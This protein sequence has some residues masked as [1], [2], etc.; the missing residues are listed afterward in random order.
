VR[1]AD[2]P[3]L[4]KDFIETAEGLIFAVVSYFPEQGKVGCFLRYVRSENG[5]SK[6][7]TE[8]ANALLM[9]KYPHYLFYS[10]QFDTSYHAVAPKDIV[11][12]HKPE[13]K[14]S[15]VLALNEPEPISHKLQQLIAILTQNGAD[16]TC[17]GLTGSML[18][19][20]QKLTSDVDL[21]VYG[22]SAFHTAR[23]AVQL[24]INGQLISE[25]DDSLMRD[26][27]ER[28]AADLSYDDFAWHEYRKFNKASIEGTKFDIG[29][30][31]LPNELTHDDEQY[32]KKGKTTLTAQ[33]IND[34]LAYDFP[35]RYIIDDL[36]ISEVLSFTHTYVGQ[37]KKGEF[38]EASGNVERNI[39]TGKSRLIVGSS[40]EAEGEYI[41]LTQHL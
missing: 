5:W 40:R 4:P 10:K 37:A 21:V 19:D 38:I 9:N 25:L 22:R 6:V 28:R 15:E 16:I 3:Y 27:F 2:F 39:K 30:T 32:E 13:V 11:M 8:Q 41:K 24:A 35:A 20:Q 33:V 26:N 17:L 34:E 36:D 12:H 23:N 18:I 14:L 7:S 31:C 1:S 29:M